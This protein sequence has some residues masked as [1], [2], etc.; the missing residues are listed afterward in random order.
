VLGRRGHLHY[1][2]LPLSPSIQLLHM[3]DN[4]DEVTPEAAL[5]VHLQHTSVGRQWVKLQ[6][7]V[8]ALRTVD[9]TGALGGSKPLIIRDS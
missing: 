4:A 5:F 7:V 6:M 2:T 8:E 9:R 1:R 3:H